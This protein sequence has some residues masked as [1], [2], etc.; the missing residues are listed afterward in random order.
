MK[1]I[2]PL[3]TRAIEQL[4]RNDN[5]D[6]LHN[7]FVPK[8]VLST[9]LFKAEAAFKGRLTNDAQQLIIPQEVSG[10]STKH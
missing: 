5:H 8:K 7:K 2:P 9:F 10:L 1:F 3:L 4:F 6:I